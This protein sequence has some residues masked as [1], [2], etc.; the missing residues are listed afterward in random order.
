MYSI[1]KAIVGSRRH[2]LNSFLIN[3]G[4][5]LSPGPISTSLSSSSDVNP[6]PNFLS[7]VKSTLLSVF[8]G[9]PPKG[10]PKV[11]NLGE[12]TPRSGTRKCK[13]H[14]IKIGS[15]REV[16]NTLRPI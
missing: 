9:C 1:S 6:Y 12:E 2:G 16:R 10:I 11:V 7:S 5:G 8:Y 13:E 4:C 3:I 14:K 15:G